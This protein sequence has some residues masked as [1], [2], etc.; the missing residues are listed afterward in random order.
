[1]PPARRTALITGGARRVGRHVALH[2]A[3]RGW[4]IAVT[5]NRSAADASALAE[6]V[7][8]LGGECVLVEADFTNP[9]AAARVAD[10]VST[11]FPRLDLLLHNASLYERGGLLETDHPQLRRLLAVHAETPVLLTQRL[12]PLLKAAGGSV[13]VM[14]DEQLDRPAPAYAAYS[15]SKAALENAVKSL[16][17]ELAPE[18]TVNA[19]APGVVEWPDDMPPAA[20]QKYLKR[21]PL[22]RAGTPQDVANLVEFLC[23]T[24]RYITGQTIRLDGGRSIR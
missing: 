4:D 19:I 12:A 21:V 20:R 1:M 15:L 24:G 5:Y 9:P 11:R 13:I 2:L 22:A 23:T 8:G 7:E 10:V 6:R 18:V 14:S 17:R 16:A 3:E